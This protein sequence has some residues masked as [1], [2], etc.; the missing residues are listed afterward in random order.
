[1]IMYNH[2]ATPLL[3]ISLKEILN[4]NDAKNLSM[5]EI[6]DKSE[7]IDINN[8]MIEL[9]KA[10]SLEQ[11]KESYG[12]IF[13]SDI[14]SNYIYSNNI[15]KSNS[16]HY[17]M[18]CKC[19]NF[20]DE[21]L[22]LEIHFSKRFDEALGSAVTFTFE[23]KTAISKL[24]DDLKILSLLPESNPNIV[25]LVSNECQ[26]VYLNPIGEAILKDNMMEDK[27]DILNLM[28]PSYL[29]CCENLCKDSRNLE[30]IINYKGKMY[31]LDI[32]PIYD[33]SMSMV[34]L[35]DITEISK[36]S[37][38]RNIFYQALE[39]S[40]QSAIITDESG[41]IIYTNRAFTDLYGYTFDQVKGKNPRFLNPGLYTY[42]EF[43]FSEKKYKNL[44]RSLWKTLSD[45]NSHNWEGS[46]INRRANG[47]LLH[48]RL[49]ISKIRD[50]ELRKT[51]YLALPIDVTENYEAFETVKLED[52]MTIASMAELRDNETG[53]HMR[54]VGLYANMLSR[55]LGQT[56]KYAKDI[57][58][59]APLHDVGKVGITDNILLA[60]RKL[61]AKE[62]EVMKTHTL[63]GFDILNKRDHMKMAADIAKYHHEKYDG[64][65]YPEGLKGEEIPLS[66]RITALCDVYDALRSIRPYKDAWTHKQAV[67]E[68]MKY[69]GSHF[70]PKVAESFRVLEKDF[71][72][73]Y[74]MN[75]DVINLD[76]DI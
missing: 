6:L 10:E 31:K 57:E 28:I 76:I 14:F 75:N 32:R 54:R 5:Y 17:C 55:F 11:F 65:G 4:S 9:F 23:D 34:I 52:L 7:I 37:E 8:S 1:M 56:S 48:V 20:L 51:F 73:I 26:V 36:I 41:D 70:D 33:K 29:E 46:V 59:F 53:F 62:F 61:T 16:G 63:L 60:P 40:N 22:V 74:N 27:N 30:G 24:N 44:F 47:E 72:E 38:E 12:E 39:N 49:N 2:I 43:G 13:P 50:E 21:D 3:T 66:A 58:S 25:I 71:E 18:I 64:T 67:D 15:E 35:T 19:K 42:Y 69:S 45:K 68:I